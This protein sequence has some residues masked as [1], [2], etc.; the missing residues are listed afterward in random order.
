[1][2]IYSENDKMKV[3]HKLYEEKKRIALELGLSY[4]ENEEQKILN[5]QNETNGN[6]KEDNDTCLIF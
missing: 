5:S 6:E 1:M 3:I 2:H 4:D